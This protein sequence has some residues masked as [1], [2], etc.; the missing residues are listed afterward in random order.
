MQCF[1]MQKPTVVAVCRRL[2]SSTAACL[3]A[4]AAPLPA[5][6]GRRRHLKRNTRG[7]FT[8]RRPDGSVNSSDRSSAAEVH[9]L[10]QPEAETAEKSTA[11][12]PL[13]LP[14]GDDVEAEYVQLLLS[15]LLEAPGEKPGDGPG[16]PHLFLSMV[17]IGAAKNRRTHTNSWQLLACKQGGGSSPMRWVKFRLPHP[18]L[19]SS[20]ATSSSSV[21]AKSMRFIWSRIFGKGS[22][23]LQCL[24]GRSLKK[25]KNLTVE[26]E[27][28]KEVIAV[29]SGDTSYNLPS[30]GTI[31]S[32]IH[33]YV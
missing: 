12:D 27:G 18:E 21:S 5:P 23:M 31:V 9:R 7:V 1:L 10:G 16:F 4:T 32:R 20:T 22:H 29:A 28:L 14:H 25:N 13:P 8:P 30:R 15:G 17:Q 24:C 6:R 26:D 19:P 11:A 3:A 33:T 2:H